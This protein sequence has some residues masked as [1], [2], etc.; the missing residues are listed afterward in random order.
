MLTLTQIKRFK[1]LKAKYAHD[2]ALLKQHPDS[3]LTEDGSNTDADLLEILEVTETQNKITD[4]IRDF[5]L[6]DFLSQEKKAELMI[7]GLAVTAA[8][9]INE[10]VRNNSISLTKAEII[11][12]SMFDQT[13]TKE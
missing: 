2:I 3:P 8:H 5:L 6:M 12:Y 13:L 11:F 1:D 9:V 4:T 7:M 10:S